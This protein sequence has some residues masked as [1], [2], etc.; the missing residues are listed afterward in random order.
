MNLQRFLIIIFFGIF[1]FSC[2]NRKKISK[3]PSKTDTGSK[4]I[5]ILE[6]YSLIL[7]QKVS[8]EPLY[9]YID[10]WIG[11]P[12]K[13]GGKDKMGV[14]C[15]NFTCN[16]LRN[17]F[18]F[19]SNFYYPSGK[20]AEKSI[21]ISKLELIEGDLV[22]FS[23]NNNSKISHVGIY[24]VNNKFVHASTSKGVIINSLDESYY[25]TRISFYGRVKK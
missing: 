19:S 4:K 9:S 14:D 8:N 17:V 10:D 1:L 13:Y 15:S 21:K 12:Y 23:I 2:G 3:V 20:L 11:I 22:F 25:K 24:L 7:N 16:L 18:N 6:K 5:T